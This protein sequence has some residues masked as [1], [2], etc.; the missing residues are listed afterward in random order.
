M[1]ALTKALH[2]AAL[3]LWCAGLIALPLVMQH[4]GRGPRGRSQAGFSEFRLLSHRAYTRVVTPAAVIAIAAGTAL[5]FMVGIDAPWLMAKLVVVAGMVLLHAWLGHLI[6][7][8]GEERGHYR[9][10]SPLP[11]LVALVVLMALVLWLVLAKPD[12]AAPVELLPDW[13]RQ[14]RGRELPSWLTPI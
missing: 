3:A 10:P 13:L 11:A 7:R 14:P 9:M 4:Y 6:A 12:L 5:I 8:T 2:V 1:I